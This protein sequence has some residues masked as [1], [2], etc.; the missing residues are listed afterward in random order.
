VTSDDQVISMDLQQN[1]PNEAM[2]IAAYCALVL[3]TILVLAW[4]LVLMFSAFIFDAP[5]RSKTDEAMRFALVI[6]VLSY[7][8][9]YLVGIAY[10]IARRTS[11]LKGQ[12][13]WTKWAVFLFLLPIIQLGLPLLIVALA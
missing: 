8:V 5:I 13:W 4:P 2:K 7:P 3:S 11:P 9:G 12:A 1:R 10:L 6:Y